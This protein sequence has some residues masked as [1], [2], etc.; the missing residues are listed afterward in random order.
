VL[1]LLCLITFGCGKSL[2]KQTQNQVRTLSGA[3]W[4]K[5]DITVSDVKESGDYAVATVTVKTAVKLRRQG[6]KWLLD[7]VR[8]DDRRWESVDRI[9]AALEAARVKE[10]ENRIERISRGVADYR[11]AHGEIPQVQGFDKLIDEL[12]PRYLD[13]V[14]RLDA[15]SSEFSYEALDS[16][17]FELRSPG[18]DRRLGTADDLMAK[19]YEK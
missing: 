2:E 17:R 15:W 16:Q 7:E 1:F 14:I 3:D 9:V 5:D 4:N 11:A 13:K 19:N 6:S 8:L 10:T 12:S 18:A